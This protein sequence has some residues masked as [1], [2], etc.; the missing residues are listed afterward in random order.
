M[1]VDFVFSD[2]SHRVMFP[3]RRGWLHMFRRWPRPENA[4]M[5]TAFI[6]EEDSMPLLSLATKLLHHALISVGFTGRTTKKRW[7]RQSDMR[8]SPRVDLEGLEQRLLLTGSLNAVASANVDSVTHGG[9]VTYRF[10]IQF[11]PGGGVGDPTAATGSSI[12]VDT[13]TCVNVAPVEVAGFNVG[14]ANVN[15]QLDSTETWQFSCAIVVPSHSNSESDPIQTTAVVTG[16]DA[17]GEPAA[18]DVSNT[19]TVDITHG[20]GSLAIIKSSSA[21][22]VAHSGSVPLRFDVSY[23]PG[24]DDAPAKN[25]SVID[26]K[27]DATPVLSAGDLNGNSFLDAGET[28]RFVCT[29]TVAATHDVQEQDPILNIGVATGQDFDGDPLLSAVSNELSLD[30]VHGIIGGTKFLD[31]DGNGQLGSEEPGLVNWTIDL[32]RDSNGNGTFDS[33]IDPH[34]D[35]AHTNAAG[36][37]IFTNL[38]PGTYFLREILQAGLTQ[39][40]PNPPGILITSSEI[41][42]GV[43]FGNKPP[44]TSIIT[45]PGDTTKTALLIV[46]TEG[47]DTFKISRQSSTEIVVRIGKTNFGTFNPTGRIIAYGLAGNDKFKVSE[48]ITLP[49]F[50]RGGSGDD[51]IFG[52]NGDDVLLGGTGNDKVTGRLGRDIL[53]GGSDADKMLGSRDE[54]ILIGG[55]TDFDANDE[56]LL[57]IL[58]EW[59]S[60]RDYPTRVTNI[61]GTGLGPRN[62]NSFFFSPILGTVHDDGVTDKLTGGGDGLDWFLA[63]LTGSA[64]DRI[65]DRAPAEFVDEI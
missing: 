50:V 13:N 51:Q 28:W 54:D 53:I 9:S 18:S 3:T 34:V 63:H 48:S 8:L 38:I 2:S 24:V 58:A 20:P 29:E 21:S 31:V 5:L 17:N 62:N 15:D 22:S 27:C 41:V 4:L 10:D 25:V 1:V 43:L 55:T 44:A 42:S 6:P 40:T 19:V 12:A 46:G 36:N 16:N 45:D 57:A 49:L 7:R 47:D 59:R 61:R 14:D 30:L 64:P 32:F 37:F 65:T 33:G 60:E 39:T 35:T 52:A 56:A 23:T 11:A 26:P